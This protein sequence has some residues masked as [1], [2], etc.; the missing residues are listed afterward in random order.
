MGDQTWFITDTVKETVRQHF[1]CFSLPG[2]AM[3]NNNV[4]GEGLLHY[5]LKKP[6]N[7]DNYWKTIEKTIFCQFFTNIPGSSQS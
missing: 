6:E 3:E 4:G 7:F 5:S 1:N 2:L